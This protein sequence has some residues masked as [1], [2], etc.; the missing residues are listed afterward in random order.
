MRRSPGSPSGASKP[1]VLVTA[2]LPIGIPDVGSA[3]E[4][5]AL[6]VETGELAVARS[7]TGNP[8]AW[9]ILRRLR[10]DAAATIDGV[11]QSQVLGGPTLLVDP[12]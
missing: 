8:L 6:D 7:V 12:T 2:T 9:A 11:L 1:A 5:L 4:V 10:P 3:G